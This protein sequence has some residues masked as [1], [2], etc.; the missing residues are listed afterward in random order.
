MLRSDWSSN[1]CSYE[2]NGGDERVDEDID[3]HALEKGGYAQE[4][5]HPAR[6]VEGLD[7]VGSQSTP[8]TEVLS[9]RGH[10]LHPY[11]RL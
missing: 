4:E 9:V 11:R 10:K 8:T 6:G 1:V 2:L 3:D 7:E 5:K